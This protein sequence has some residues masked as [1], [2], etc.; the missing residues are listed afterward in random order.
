MLSTRETI[1][2]TT[3]RVKHN[4]ERTGADKG[5][6]QTVVDLVGHGV[7]RG[8]VGAT[9][10]VHVRGH[11]V[12]HLQSFLLKWIESLKRQNAKRKRRQKIK[13]ANKQ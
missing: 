11:R 13:D 12:T 9:L 7:V 5:K 1:H 3:T 10:V 8:D 2:K 4:N 6:A